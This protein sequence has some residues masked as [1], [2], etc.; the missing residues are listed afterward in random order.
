MVF[1]VFG[2]ELRSDSL[3]FMNLRITKVSV[4][5]YKLGNKNNPF[6]IWILLCIWSKFLGTSFAFVSFLLVKAI[7]R[8]LYGALAFE[9]FG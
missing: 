8:S 6:F 1:Y 9:T 5:S 4:F 3:I 7:E 2:L